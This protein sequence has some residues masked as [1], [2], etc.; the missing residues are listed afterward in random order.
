MQTVRDTDILQHIILT[1]EP[2]T[3]ATFIH[4]KTC[5]FK[6]NKNVPIDAQNEFH[7][8]DHATMS[9]GTLCL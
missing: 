4:T 9:H 2:F 3:Y 6:S 1:S 5:I 7:G 8:Q